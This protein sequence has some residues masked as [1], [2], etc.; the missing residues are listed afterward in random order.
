MTN[1][2]A[3]ASVQP[4]AATSNVLVESCPDPACTAPTAA[5]GA[6]NKSTCAASDSTSSAPPTMQR[7]VTTVSSDESTKEVASASPDDPAVK[8]NNDAPVV[9]RF[10]PPKSEDGVVCAPS[11]SYNT[12]AKS[13][14]GVATAISASDT[15]KASAPK[16]NHVMKKC[17]PP[18][19]HQPST[20]NKDGIV[21]APDASTTAKSNADAGVATA[22]LSDATAEA[23]ASALKNDYL[24]KK[25]L[26]S[27]VY[28]AG[29][30]NSVVRAAGT[31]HTTTETSIKSADIATVVSNDAA[32]IEQA[33]APKDD[34]LVKECLPPVVHRPHASNNEDGN[35]SAPAPGTSHAHGEVGGT[36]IT[37]AVP[38]EQSSKVVAKSVRNDT[39][40]TA[41]VSKDEVAC[42]SNHVANGK[43]HTIA[44]EA[45]GSSRVL[46]AILPTIEVGGL[47]T[48]RLDGVSIVAAP[49]KINAI[50]NA[51][52]K[53]R[54]SEE[55]Q[56]IAKK[57]AK[58]AKDPNAPKKH[59][60]PYMHYA[61]YARAWIK[62][63][64]PNVTASV[65]TNTVREGWKEMSDDARRVWNGKSAADKARYEKEL[66]VYKN[67][68]QGKAWQARVAEVS[69]QVTS[70]TAIDTTGDLKKAEDST[71]PKPY[72]TA[73]MLYS[74]HAR[75]WLKSRNP[76]LTNEEMTKSVTDGWNEMD[77]RALRYWNDRSAA[78][79]ARYEKELAEHELG[80]AWQSQAN[81]A[82]ESKQPTI[83]ATRDMKKAAY[84]NAPKPNKSA[85]M[86]YIGYALPQ[87][88][89]T[90]PQ[91][92]DAEATNAV[93][94][95]WD[96]MIPE[97]R[98][99]WD[100]IAAADKVRYQQE[101]VLFKAGF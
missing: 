98:N 80:Q 35:V 65:A 22:D 74:D 43:V 33:S 69:K 18:V 79:K 71:A 24:V 29:A 47:I 62:A 20:K 1:I 64:N 56:L 42:A 52:A 57:K 8:D 5:S 68:E 21:S 44:T 85:F 99:Y 2:E 87:I 15:E 32:V 97:V 91:M 70:K 61:T 6:S 53:K 37:N 12:T 73:Y 72:G 11:T 34:H 84:S 28:R 92:E 82:A 66:A 48:K 19:V 93:Q 30:S 60:T 38:S 4:I 25:C 63:R 40:A 94:R 76:S 86:H 13:N 50:E 3:T 88:S 9:R 89:L 10:N 96:I 7:I 31:S 51:L 41:K 46:T 49:A 36:D 67:S 55:E 39:F 95:G 26:P 83:H 54:K 45:T 23:K 78:D 58:V 14:A 59:M 77:Y 27:V 75:A 100:G 90:Y 101:L 81:V 16:E 17:L